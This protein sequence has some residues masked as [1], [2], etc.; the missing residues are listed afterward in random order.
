M[1]IQMKIAG[2]IQD[3]IVDGP[4][5]RFAVFTQG[6]TLC[7]PGCQNPDTWDASGGV[8]LSVNYIINEMLSNPLTDGLSLS[9]GEPFEQ[10]ADCASLAAIARENGLSVWIFTGKTYEELLEEAKCD[11]D[12]HKLL[13]LTDVLVD[14][15][16][17]LAERTLAIKW[18]GSKNQRIIDVQK[19]LKSGKGEFYYERQGQGAIS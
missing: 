14:G 12:V 11:F 16:F 3:S 1:V 15:R 9:G 4:G 5:L 18:C 10:A 6:C 13:T 7:C 17:I 8:E 2:L 19:S